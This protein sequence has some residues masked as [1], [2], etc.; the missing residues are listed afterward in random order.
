MNCRSDSEVLDLMGN[1]VVDYLSFIRDLV[2]DSDCLIYESSL[3][4]T[5][6]SGIALVVSGEFTE[7][8]DIALNF[9]SA[10]DSTDQ[11]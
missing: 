6:D 10:E 5:Q 4:G 1:A 2:L 8:S 9:S 7:V 3:D 11:D